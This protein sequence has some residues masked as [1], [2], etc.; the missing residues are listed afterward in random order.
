MKMELDDNTITVEFIQSKIY[1]F[2]GYAVMIDRDLADLYGV[3]TRVLNQAVKRHEHRFPA[4]F[5]FQMTKAEME[6]WKSQIVISNSEKM[7][8][9]KPPLRLLNKV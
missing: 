3:E 1:Q 6:H 2:R 9:R 5:M 8:L 4:D 7:G